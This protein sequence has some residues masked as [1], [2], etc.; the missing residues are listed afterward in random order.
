VTMLVTGDAFGNAD[1]SRALSRVGPLAPK[2]VAPG[3]DVA[4]APVSIKL[5]IGT[6]AVRGEGITMM[7]SLCVALALSV[8]SISSTFANP[9]PA[10]TAERATRVEI[11]VT[12]KGFEPEQIKVPANK[13]VT[14]VFRRTTDKTC[15]KQVV[16][17]ISDTQKIEKDL[18][19]NKTVE[20]AATFPK[21]G[22]LSYT[23]SMDMIR[24][25]LTVI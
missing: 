1:V 6:R 24:G 9:A 4:S 23:C 16:I 10:K 3:C 22:Q 11:T 7:K 5:T 15:A 20:I 19:L 25:T 14:L 2:H 21:A 13:P 8:V 12:E 17:K 18:P